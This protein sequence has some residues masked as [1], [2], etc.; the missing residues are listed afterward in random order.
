MITIEKQEVEFP[1]LCNL[2]DREY[3]V[4]VPYF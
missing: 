3:N 4:A 1:V 2:V